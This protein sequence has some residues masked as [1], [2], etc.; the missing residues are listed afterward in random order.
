VEEGADTEVAQWLLERRVDAAFVILPDERFDTVPVAE[1]Q[2]VALVP[3]NHALASRRTV[4]LDELCGTSFIM[5]EAGSAALIEPLFTSAGLALKPHYRMAQIITILGMVERGDGTSIVAELALPE[6]LSR[7]H[8]GIVK[9]PLRP[10]VKRR[11]GL[12]VRNSRHV[13]PAARALLDVAR[14]LARASKSG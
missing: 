4:P 7:T 14:E 1:D 12:A 2:L 11:V 13:T 6:N 3:A 10:A 9:L 8:P 5:T